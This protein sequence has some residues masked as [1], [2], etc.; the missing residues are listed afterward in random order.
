MSFES[1]SLGDLHKFMLTCPFSFQHDITLFAVSPLHR[2][3]WS[4]SYAE[5]FHI[6]TT[7]GLHFK[8]FKSRHF[9]LSNSDR[10]DPFIRGNFAFGNKNNIG[11]GC[12]ALSKFPLQKWTRQGVE[13]R[14]QQEVI[15][16][17]VLSPSGDGFLT[18]FPPLVRLVSSL[19]MKPGRCCRGGALSCVPG[20]RCSESSA[21]LSGSR[22]SGLRLRLRLKRRSSAVRTERRSLEIGER[23]RRCRVI[24]RLLTF[25][26]FCSIWYFF[27]FGIC[28]LLAQAVLCVQRSV[29]RICFWWPVSFSVTSVGEFWGRALNCYHY[30]QDAHVALSSKMSTH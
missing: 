18:F 24:T 6:C 14:V 2:D 21:P 30:F 29:L 10:K 26:V 4:S 15:L 8:W 9:P 27:G 23:R 17:P 11:F 19:L 12:S 13:A 22:L 5:W 1:T 16:I 7:K 20:A 28:F 25:R 3:A